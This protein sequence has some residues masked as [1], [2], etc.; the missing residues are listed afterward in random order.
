MHPLLAL[1]DALE[2]ICSQVVV[3]EVLHALLDEL[4]EVICLGTASLRGQEVQSLFYIG[5]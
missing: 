3:L 1:A 5:G 4:P 2:D